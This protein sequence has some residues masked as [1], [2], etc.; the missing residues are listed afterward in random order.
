MVCP[1]GA[2]AR[3]PMQAEAY[4]YQVF[5]NHWLA[6]AEAVAPQ[7]GGVFGNGTRVVWKFD[8]A[9]HDEGGWR[10]CHEVQRVAVELDVAGW[11]E[12][13]D[14]LPQEG[15]DVLSLLVFQNDAAGAQALN[16]RVFRG[17]E[18]SGWGGRPRE[19]AVGFRRSNSCK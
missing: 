7:G 15:L 10:G 1:T 16:D 18:L 2:D 9:G 6:G 17:T 14:V 11:L 8:C 3:R 12:A 4:A 13:I 5:W 19:G